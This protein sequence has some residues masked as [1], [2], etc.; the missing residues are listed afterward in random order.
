MNRPNLAKGT[1]HLIL[2]LILACLFSI[3]SCNTEHKHEHSTMAASDL[4]GAANELDSLFLV[5]FNKGDAEAIMKLHWNSPEL[6][7]YPPGGEMQMKG[8]DAVKAAYVRDF[9]TNKGA[10]LEYTSVNNI[11]F[12]DVV[13]GHGT[14]KWSMTKEDGS[15]MEF[16]G[17]YTEVKAMKDG[18]MVIIVDHTSVPMMTEEE[19]KEEETEEQ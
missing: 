17:R 18:K 4:I 8:Y 19:G 5:A 15:P 2:G 16:H 1:S 3:T 14:F 13:V 7:A 11:P 6:R 9:A 12:V 10:K